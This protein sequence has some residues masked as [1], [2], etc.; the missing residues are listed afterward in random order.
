MSGYIFFYI[1]IKIFFRVLWT[2]FP[3]SGYFFKLIYD[4]N[5]T[6]NCPLPIQYNTIR[7]K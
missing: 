1:D 2:P 3:E 4:V 6:V 7:V 5:L